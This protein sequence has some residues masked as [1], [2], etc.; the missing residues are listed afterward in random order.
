MKR[1]LSHLNRTGQD[2]LSLDQTTFSS[3][4]WFLIYDNPFL[5]FS[6]YISDY[7]YYIYDFSPY[8]VSHSYISM[9][10]YI[11][12]FKYNVL[13]VA[14][15]CLFVEHDLFPIRII[16]VVQSQGIEFL[17]SF[18]LLSKSYQTFLFDKHWWR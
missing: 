5:Y 14:S 3:I 12:G 9:L 1:L 16:Q 2:R 15:L 7:K 13:V 18:S 4:G 11:S 6:Q 17:Q 8:M 10:Q